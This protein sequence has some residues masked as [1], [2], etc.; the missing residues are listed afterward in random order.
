MISILNFTRRFMLLTFVGQFDWVVGIKVN[1]GLFLDFSG[2]IFLFS[3]NYP[4]ISSLLLIWTIQM[5]TSLI[6]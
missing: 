3:I 6:F 4:L 2:F 5:L 1:F